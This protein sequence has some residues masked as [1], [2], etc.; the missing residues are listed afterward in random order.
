MRCRHDQR[1]QVSLI[2]CSRRVWSVQSKRR[3]RRE[4]S[5]TERTMNRNV[6]EIDSDIGSWFLPKFALAPILIK[7]NS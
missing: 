1:A 6:G 2:S 7:P 3:E 5:T 4:V